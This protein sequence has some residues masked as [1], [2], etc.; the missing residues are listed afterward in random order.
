M[1]PHQ[2]LV[3]QESWKALE[4]AGYNPKVLA[5]T[6]TGVFIGAEP[7]N[8][9]QGSF[10][11]SSEAIIASRVSYFLDMKGPALV[12]NTGCSSSAVAIHL[13]CESLRRRETD[14][15][16][17]GGVFA[18]LDAGALASLSSIGMLSHRAECPI[19]EQMA[20]GM[21]LS[22]GIGI[23]A[24]KRLDQAITDGDPIYG[25]IRASGMNQDGASNGIT[26]P[27]GTAQQQL[28][29]QVYH[30]YHINP[31]EISY[32]EA[33]AT[34]GKLGDTIEV[35]ALARTFKALT[36]K[37]HYCALGSVKS[38]IGH[39]S[40]ASGVIGLIK[41]LL[42]MRHRQL[43]GLRHYQQINPLF[44]LQDSAFYIQ[45]TTSV[46][47]NHADRPRL[48]ALNSFGH[49]GTNAHLVIEEY[50][51]DRVQATEPVTAGWIIPLSAKTTQS[52]QAQIQGLCAY[53]EDA[54]R[55]R[56]DW[57]NSGPDD[58]A[59]SF[60]Q[61]IAYTLQVGREAM[62][63]RFFLIA[64]D[65]RDCLQQLQA[66]CRQKIS[67][68]HFFG[69]APIAGRKQQ[70][71]AADAY[72]HRRLHSLSRSELEAIGQAWLQG[73]PV[74]WQSFYLQ[75]PARIHLPGYV[76]AKD[77]FRA[78]LPASE[79]GVAEKSAGD[80]DLIEEGRYPIGRAGFFT[81]NHPWSQPFNHHHRILHNHQAFGQSL[82]PGLA[83]IDL[84]FQFFHRQGMDYRQLEMRN[85][86]IHYPF[87]IGDDYGVD[88]QIS[89]QKSTQGYWHLKVEG[90]EV[91][92]DQQ[93]S[94]LK[95]YMSAEMHPVPVSVFNETLDVDGLKKTAIS[96]MR[97]QDAY[98]EFGGE[99]I[100]HCGPMVG[101]GVIYHLPSA[102]LIDIAVPD[103]SLFGAEHY[104]FH[105]VLID[106][107]AIGSG[108]LFLEKNKA[109][110]IFCRFITSLSA[111]Q[112][113]CRDT[114]LPASAVHH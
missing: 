82:L 42:S 86:T 60:I 49:S 1:S 102:N 87:T 36:D 99:D 50:L 41:I 78:P 44:E 20:D 63:E 46:W 67:T 55:Q 64:K 21:L 23:V 13:A 5:G 111:R 114:V 66:F 48:A 91:S 4:D 59:L 76:F 29:E 100:R 56:T 31:E 39:T 90:R 96:Q 97:L 79:A 8:Y 81:E 10:V 85:L 15:A 75:P 110:D 51:P 73:K 43:P 34:G 72:Q 17:A 62:P 71:L 24:L 7:S 89:C 18:A 2:R 58:D 70:A 98:V 61:S 54:D 104:L 94:G 109:Q 28:L 37:Q 53:L 80:G 33:H 9:H 105:P 32:I 77:V 40:A 35:N 108:D 14:L 69:H 38:H 113:R 3:L 6:N 25:V 74:D 103:E 26:A 57:Q 16:L 65:H 12:V 52:L 68:D 22:E 93:Q 19:F 84:L 30:K 83:Y 112:N 45:N 107:S 92:D 95:L 11:G 101:D 106:G 27:S 47:K 88:A